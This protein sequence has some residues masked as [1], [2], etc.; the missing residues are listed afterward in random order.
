M[1]RAH[2]GDVEAEPARVHG[3]RESLCDPRVVDGQESR[4]GGNCRA[5]AWIGDY[6]ETRRRGGPRGGASRVVRGSPG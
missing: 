4:R 3:V 5:R 6:F 1:V 2:G